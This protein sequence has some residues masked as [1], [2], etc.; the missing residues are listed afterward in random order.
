[1]ARSSYGPFGPFTGKLGPLNGYVLRGKGV[2]RLNP[3]IVKPRSINQ[4]AVQQKMQV[5]SP[6][7][8]LIKIYLRVGFE[9]VAIK[10]GNSAYN[11]AMSYN[12]TNAITG[13]YPLQEVNYPAVRLSQGSLALPLNPTTSAVPGGIRFSWDFDQYDSSGDGYDRTMLMVYFPD[14][15]VN[16]SWY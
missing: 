12:L 7:I 8:N 1:M 9:L 4:L 15:K 3:H 14:K 11:S 2:L 13:T 16:A 5:L 10:N 6:F